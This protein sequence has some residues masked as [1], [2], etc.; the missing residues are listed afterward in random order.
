MGFLHQATTRL[1]AS[2]ITFIQDAY[3]ITLIESMALRLLG[4]GNASFLWPANET[5]VVGS[6]GFL[7]H[8]GS[9]GPLINTING[10]L[11]LFV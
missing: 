2:Q 3:L 10:K 7:Y 5:G 11:L 1:N 8:N 6:D 4:I 9:L